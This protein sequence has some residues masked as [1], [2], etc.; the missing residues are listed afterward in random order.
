MVG[1][2]NEAKDATKRKKESREGGKGENVV[3]EGE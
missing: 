1:G 2:E 3:V